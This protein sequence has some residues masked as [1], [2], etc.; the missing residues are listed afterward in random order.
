MHSQLTTLINHLRE[1]TAKRTTWLVSPQSKSWLSGAPKK[2][3]SSIWASSDACQPLRKASQRPKTTV[4][5]LLRKIY[6]KMYQPESS[7]LQERSS[8]VKFKAPPKSELS[9]RWASMCRLRR[10]ARALP[11]S[12]VPRRQNLSKG[13]LEVALSK[14]L[15]QKKRTRW[16]SSQ[17]C[18]N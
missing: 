16:S 14:S 6:A 2:I 3:K 4:S 13:Y 7:C 9:K 5:S 15:T 18:A 10:L 12:K 11:Q 1:G 8:K 17:K